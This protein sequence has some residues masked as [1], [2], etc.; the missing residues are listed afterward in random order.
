[1][2]RRAWLTLGIACGL[3]GPA[4]AYV[5][6]RG[7]DGYPLEW[8]RRCIPFWIN[9]AGSE[10]IPTFSVVENGVLA[11]F[12]VWEDVACSDLEFPYQGTTTIDTVGADFRN[13][14]MFVDDDW[15]HGAMV[16]A[17][18][19]T[20]FCQKSDGGRCD[21]E[22]RI[23]DA[24]IE[25]NGEHFDFTHTTNPI[26][27]RFDLR[28][29]VAHEV[30]HLLGLDHTPV[31]EATMYPSADPRETFKASLHA[32]DIEGLCD[33]YP[34]AETEPAPCEPIDEPP[35]GEAE[36]GCAQVGATPAIPLIFLGI[37]GLLRRRR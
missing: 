24:D 15:D 2:T 34:S 4:A 35:S 12:A 22:G 19:T 5:R 30:G 28:N 21:V 1:M 10:D 32:D 7:G 25:L 8:S 6:S 37:L 26:R 23:L 3:S 9:E 20:T 17:L 31:P 29:T 18:T 36:A 16:I 13:V 33:L 27:I 14:V 11:S